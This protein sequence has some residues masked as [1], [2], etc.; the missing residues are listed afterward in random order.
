MRN[1]TYFIVFKKKSKGLENQ[2]IFFA[3]EQKK[4]RIEGGKRARTC[5]SIFLLF[6][7]V[8][9]LFNYVQ[10][11]IKIFTIKKVIKIVKEDGDFESNE[12]MAIT[13]HQLI[14]LN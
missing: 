1:P 3:I 5:F 10:K 11:S 9:W 8:L 13:G 12:R 2:K 14:K 6:E 7:L 4:V